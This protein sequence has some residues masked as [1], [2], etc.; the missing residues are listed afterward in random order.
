M[1]VYNK[2]SENNAFI[3]YNKLLD[4]YNNKDSLEN[5]ISSLKK[6]IQNE[7]LKE[8]TDIFNY[9]PIYENSNLIKDGQHGW[10]IR[11]KKDISKG[12]GF[13]PDEIVKDI[14][15]LFKW[16]NVAEHPEDNQKVLYGN[17]LGVY[18]G[19]AQVIKFFSKIDI[20]KEIMNIIHKC[21]E[22][23]DKDK[24]KLNIKNSLNKKKKEK[25]RNNYSGY[26][27]VNT[28]IRHDPVRKWENNIKYKYISAGNDIRYINRIRTLKKNDKIF[29][30]TPEKGYVGYGIVEEEAVLVKEYVVGG[31]KMLNKTNDFP[32]KHKWKQNKDQ[33]VDEWIVKVDWKKTVEENNAVP[34][35]DNPFPYI[36][37]VCRL[38]KETLD[39]L[40]EE[41]IIDKNK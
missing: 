30:Y 37:N 32:E 16:R 6:L 13:I 29:A 11:N 31:D 24:L 41:F 25:N 8:V 35:K 19:V 20:P 22:K 14:E 39:Y 18:T 4:N 33:N 9:N 15:S 10:L 17:Y 26:Y 27:F 2:I 40:K 1:A 34:N 5:K 23:T 7:I 12:T 36:N 28:G 3:Y 38:N 21:E